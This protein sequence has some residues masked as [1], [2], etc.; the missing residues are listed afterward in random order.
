MFNS[1]RKGKSTIIMKLI[2]YYT[3]NESRKYKSREPNKTTDET[4]EGIEKMQCILNYQE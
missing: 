2:N 3:K 1:S 4:L